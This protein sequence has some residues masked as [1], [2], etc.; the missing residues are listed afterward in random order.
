MIVFGEKHSISLIPPLSYLSS[1]YETTVNSRLVY[2][3]VK[4]GNRVETP[5]FVPKH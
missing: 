2:F 1:K 4:T 5:N 3:N